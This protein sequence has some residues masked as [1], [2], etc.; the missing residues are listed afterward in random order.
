MKNVLSAIVG[1]LCILVI[2]AFGINSYIKNK[3]N[4]FGA[5]CPMVI[6]EVT[7]LNSVKYDGIFH[8][9]F[10]YAVLNQLTSSIILLMRDDKQAVN[11]LKAELCRNNVLAEDYFVDQ[12]HI[13][14]DS[15]SNTTIL[16]VS[17]TSEECESGNFDNS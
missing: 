14:T 11:T 7:V 12:T 15:L 4:A 5:A 9:K 6:D 3:V 2:V 13:F 8:A 1:V 17:F 16:K 10:N